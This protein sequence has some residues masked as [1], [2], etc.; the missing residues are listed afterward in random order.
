M[1]ILKSNHDGE[2]AA[3]DQSHEENTFGNGF[4]SMPSP[5][6]SSNKYEDQLIESTKTEMGEVKEEN[7]RLKKLLSKV[8]NDCRS[9][10]MHIFDIVKQD[11]SKASTNDHQLPPNLSH[12]LEPEET[13]LV[14]LRLG[15]AR[16]K[17]VDEMIKTNTH[18]VEGNDPIERQGL[19]LGL[20]CKFDEHKEPAQLKDPNPKE[21]EVGDQTSSPGKITKLNLRSGDD[22]VLQQSHAKKAR[23]SVRVRCET[24]TIMDGCQW[25]KYGQ[26]T[27]KGNPCPRAYY[28]C[29]VGPACPVRKQ[30]QRCAED[31]SVLITTYEGN[32]N[33]HLPFSASAMASTTTAAASMLMTGSSISN[34]GVRTQLPTSA[35]SSPTTPAIT[36]FMNSSLQ[37]L[38]FDLSDNSRTLLRLANTTITPSYS[39]IT[40]DLA[41][42]SPSTGAAQTTQLNW[43]SSSSNNFSPSMP[44]SWSSKRCMSYAHNMARPM[45]QTSLTD[46]VAKAITTDPSFQSAIRAAITSYV[47]ASAGR[48]SSSSVVC[49]Q[50]NNGGKA[51]K[52][53]ALTGS[54]PSSSSP[55]KGSLELSTLMA[56]SRSKGTVS[57]S[58]VDVIRWENMK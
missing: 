47:G 29:S 32:H 4:N 15:S 21:E 42:Q 46:S 30:V 6:L 12:H 24:P 16:Y 28:R 44:S 2:E 55:Q 36:G 57:G 23:V 8:V 9:L 1:E 54:A 31:M 20:D 58:S 52:S 51:Y 56:M 43:F 37:S 26:K 53:A 3:V 17:M 7:Q 19:A 5:P 49:E 39:T 33:H 22:E 18:E 34:L 45:N 38:N 27:A 11:K 10:Q 13:E 48:G 35:F 25:R 41:A 14:S 50:S 40:L